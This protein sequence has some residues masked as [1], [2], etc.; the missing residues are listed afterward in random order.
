[1]W[2]GTATLR[3]VTDPTLN[4]D[5][6]EAP[7]A[8][9]VF[10]RR[11][12]PI[13]DRKFRTFGIEVETDDDRFDVLMEAY[14]DP[15]AGAVYN[16]MG[17]RTEVQQAQAAAVLLGS[18]TRDD[19]GAPLDWSPPVEPA[20]DDDGQIIRDEPDSANPEG[21]PL[22]EWWNGD[23]VTAAELRERRA[24]FDPIEHG[25]SRRRFQFI[26]D[27]PH[28]RVQLGALNEVAEFVVGDA[29][30]RPTRRP[31]P[32]GRGPLPTARTSR[33]RRR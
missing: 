13:N 5:P 20:Y 25:S 4:G 33:A 21:E 8:V 16:L 26:M 9:P 27:S 14:L 6:P 15:D 30:K 1:M 3:R 22:Y 7:P 29:A 19:D 17:A 11:A 32:S 23:L 10:G 31:T 12:E 28:H 24:E 18:S 2:G